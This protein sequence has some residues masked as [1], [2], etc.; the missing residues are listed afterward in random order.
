MVAK[1]ETL[2]AVL[3][4]TPQAARLA[5]L[6][7]EMLAGGLARQRAESKAATMAD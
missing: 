6:W 5:A 4:E 3:K 7:A 1:T 2:L